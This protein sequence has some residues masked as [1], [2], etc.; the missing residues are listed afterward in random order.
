[1]FTVYVREEDSG[2]L[3]T[4]QLGA[5]EVLRPVR[6]LVG[7]VASPFVTAREAVER[8]LDS[9]EKKALEERA[10]KYEGNAA[11]AA[12]LRQENER[13]RKL[14]KGERAS[15]EYSPLARVV[16][17]VGGQ[18]TERAVIDIGADEGVK[19][20]QPVVVGDN[21]LVGRTTSQI[22]PN[23]AEVLL[24]TDPTFAAG[25]RIVP[26]AAP[27]RTTS[28]ES[29]SREETT[30]R[31]TTISEEPSSAEGLLRSNWEG[32]LGVD[33]VNLSAEAEQGDF[34][35]TSGRAGEKELLFPPGLLVG[36]IESV[37]SQDI[38]Q[39]KKIVVTPTAKVDDL[40]EVRVI[41][42]W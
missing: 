28:G 19:P 40:Y 7:L 32:Y 33:Y 41:T 21:V 1:L 39:Y 35:V 31:E 14:L 4:V 3:H 23:T 25:V 12:R 8:A 5:A 34:V 11:Q 22:T 17:P 38:D 13:L 37:S 2:P 18:L 16:A 27:E 30:P 42:D 36:T 10:Q 6:G 29:T 24:V 20:E 9:G 15:F 26:P